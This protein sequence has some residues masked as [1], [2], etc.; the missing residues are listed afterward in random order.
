MLQLLLST[1]DLTLFTY[2]LK[3]RMNALI[4]EIWQEKSD[5]LNL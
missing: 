5:V 2:I 1:E 4:R 3:H